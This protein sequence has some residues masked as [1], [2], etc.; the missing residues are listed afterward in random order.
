MMCA[1]RENPSGAEHS[2]RPRAAK[3][4]IVGNHTCANRGDGSILR[5]LIAG[6]EDRIPD[7]E[8]SIISRFA[9]ASSYLLG[10][11]VLDDAVFNHGRGHRIK[12]RLYLA[13]KHRACVFAAK[14]P[15]LARKV[16]WPEAIE[17]S[18][19][20]FC[21]QDAII[22]VGGSFFIDLY[23]SG[24]YDTFMIELAARRPIVLAGHSLGP[25]RTRRSRKLARFALSRVQRIV[26]RESKSIDYVQQLGLPDDLWT[27][28]GDTAWLAPQ[29]DEQ[30]MKKAEVALAD[31]PGPFVAMSARV[32]SPFD[33]SLGVK[34]REYE[35]RFTRMLD[36]V[37]ESGYTVVGVSM[38]T[39]LDGYDRD[40]RMVALRIRSKLRY[41]DRMAVLMD[42]F[43]DLEI[44][45]ILSRCELT[46]GTRLH[47]AILSIHTG[48]PA[49]GIAYE[50]KLPGTFKALG[51]DDM[52]IT[53]DAMA[54]DRSKCLIRDVLENPREARQRVSQGVK[55]ERKR[56][57]VSIDA[58]EECLGRK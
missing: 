49:I 19:R 52:L 2:G 34:Q 8:L 33:I 15:V 26:L 11:D 48:T 39:G 42:E 36:W 24:Q 21:N 40:D 51:L 10:R 56:A 20:L 22:Q 31:L 13:A 47:S 32:L 38:C 14:C 53:V 1:E 4:C 46:I 44:A 57:W 43:N 30:A 16:R 29:P 23:G 18:Y 12:H 58:V 45:A 28:G 25:F 37:V 55:Q 7:A 6:I 35:S 17:G 5:G 9:G 3:L 41:P 54:S 27:L 50:H